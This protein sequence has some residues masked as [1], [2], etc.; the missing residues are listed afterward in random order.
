MSLVA[1]R[2]SRVGRAAGARDLAAFLPTT[3]EEMRARAWDELDVLIVT[4]DAYVDHPAFGPVLVARFLAGRGLR[5]G[6]V[7]QPRWTTPEDVARMGRPRLFVGV[8]AGNLDSMLNKLTAQKKVRSEDQYSPGGRTNMRP[9]RA[10]LVY[11][12]LCRQ[13]FPGLPVVIGGIEASLRRIA[14]YDYWSDS[15]RRSILL[16]SKA[17]LLVF[18]MGELAAWEIARRLDAGERLEQLTDVRGTA[19]VRKN[20]RAWEGVGRERQPVRHRRQARP[21]AVVRGSRDDKVAFAKM[22]RMLQFETNAHNARP[23]LQPHGDE[24]VYFNPP[25]LP[26]AESEMDALY[27]LPFVRRPHWGYGDEQHPRVRDGQEL[28]RDDARLLRR[29]HVLQHHRARGPDHPEPQRRQRAS[30]GARALA[31]GGVPRHDHRRRRAR[32]RT[33]TRCACKDERHRAARAGASRACT[34]ASARTS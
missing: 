12:N 33:C 34:R 28:D 22:S 31:H 9:N 32:P 26:L 7:A 6:I 16:D 30:R 4:G 20:R 2:T 21:P 5:V 18:G 8:S 14:H 3:R 24:A 11:A 10:T 1:L 17:D 27:D 25:A 15:V 19:H 29:V 23:L 13:A